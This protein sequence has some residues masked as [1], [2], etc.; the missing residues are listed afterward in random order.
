M[1]W[2]FRFLKKLFTSFIFI[3]GFLCFL[4]ILLVG[5]KAFFIP[6]LKNPSVLKIKLKENFKEGGTN[7]LMELFKEDSLS[8]YQLLN[9]LKEAKED[10][11]IK[12]V[13]IYGSA[14]TLGIAQVE[15][16]RSLIKEIREKKPVY[17]YT[18]S[19][20]ELSGGVI[21]YYLASVAS[22]IYMQPLGGV[23]L[24]GLG[25]ELTFFK[26]L[27]DK[28]GV[29]PQFFYREEYK[30][31]IEPYIRENMS[32]PSKQSWK[33]IF[34][35]LE[36]GVAKD[37]AFEQ[38]CSS[39]RIKKILHEGPYTGKEGIALRLING[40]LSKEAFEKKV[41]KTIGSDSEMV[42]DMRYCEVLEKRAFKKKLYGIF[43]FKPSEYVALLSLSGPIMRGESSLFEEGVFS[44]DI[45]EKLN[46]LAKDEDAKAIVIRIDSPGGDAVASECIRSALEVC[47]KKGKIIIVS[48]GNTAASGGYWIA[49]EGDKIFSGANTLT[50]SIGVF[51]GKFDISE[52]LGKVD[53]NIDGVKTSDNANI[54]SA[55]H[56]FSE[57]DKEKMEKITEEIYQHFLHLV[58]DKRKMTLDQVRSVAKGRVWIGSEAKK[59]GLVDRIGGLLDAI[60]EAKKMA[61]LD[62]SALVKDVSLSSGILSFFV[63]DQ[64]TCSKITWFLQMLGIGSS[65]RNYAYDARL[66]GKTK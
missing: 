57:T 5:R 7:V 55:L 24:T 42:S 59:I 15:E 30:G 35:A 11:A 31:A 19:L 9:V 34:A 26:N 40:I 17:F 25:I 18:A 61:N 4:F 16:L 51:M 13:S 45:V 39:E 28:L 21:P 32:E 6:K 60:S 37:I 63:K 20:G 22:K 50:G 3:L 48:M 53:I 64:E 52:L 46:I 66:C 58:A 33:D 23:G 2:I 47:R 38:N 29:N 27:F 41:K 54:E 65:L 56:P 8:F 62:K 36:N 44:Q 1:W 10:T 43:Q 12:A 14:C 49:S